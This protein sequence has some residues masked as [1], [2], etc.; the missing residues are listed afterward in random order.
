[1]PTGNGVAVNLN[2]DKK[3]KKKK[4]NDPY[5][6]TMDKCS[7]DTYH[8]KLG[9]LQIASPRSAHRKKA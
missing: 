7:R 1:M 4:P 3:K 9:N 5:A 2:L 6:M 8:I